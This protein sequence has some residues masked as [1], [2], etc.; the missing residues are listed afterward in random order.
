M[1]FRKSLVG[2]LVAGAIA[3]CSS[4]SN[5][6]SPYCRHL[7]DVSS[8]LARAQQ[9]LFQNGERGQAALS[10]IVT[11]LQGLQRDAPAEIR[12]ALAELVTAFQEADQALQQPGKAAQQQLADA[13]HVLSTDGRK[14][15]DYVASKCT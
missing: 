8:R 6:S 13:A 7:S 3:G 1:H 5:E 2:L 4:G 9:D 14:V 15:T 11:E 10:R 12:Q